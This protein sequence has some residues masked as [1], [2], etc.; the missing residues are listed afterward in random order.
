MCILVWKGTWRWKLIKVCWDEA[1]TP[2]LEHVLLLGGIFLH[3]FICC[4]LKRC[5]LGG[6][7]IVSVL[8]IHIPRPKQWWSHPVMT[9]LSALISGLGHQ[10]DGER[11]GWAGQG[12]AGQGCEWD[13]LEK[14]WGSFMW[15]PLAGQNPS[16]GPRPRAPLS[17]PACLLWAQ[18]RRTLPA[19]QLACFIAGGW[20][21]EFSAGDCSFPAVSCGIVFSQLVLKFIFLTLLDLPHP[22]SG[23]WKGVHWGLQHRLAYTLL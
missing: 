20:V 23:H 15:V 7:W 19:S 1:L 21:P 18:H 8:Q 2:T 9:D 10:G 5:E 22:F 6:T 13:T 17:Q 12:G 3:D 14:L 11:P 16:S 4:F